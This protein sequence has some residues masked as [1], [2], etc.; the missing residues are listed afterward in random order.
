MAQRWKLRLRELW[1]LSA[2]E[3]LRQWSHSYLLRILASQ[4]PQ[5]IKGFV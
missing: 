4:D 1:S 2:L 3:F 5:S